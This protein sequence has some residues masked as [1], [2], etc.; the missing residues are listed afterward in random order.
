MDEEKNG[1]SQRPPLPFTSRRT[2]GRGLFCPPQ[3]SSAGLVKEPSFGCSIPMG[4]SRR[5]KACD[6]E[7]AGRG[8]ARQ[9]QYIR[10]GSANLMKTVVERINM[11]RALLGMS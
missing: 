7:Y 2:A 1:K 5:W 6:F 9:R 10:T 11:E 4:R 8:K 3:K